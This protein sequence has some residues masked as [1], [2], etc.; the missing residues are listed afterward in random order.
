[1]YAKDHIG[2]GPRARKIGG[3]VLATLVGEVLLILLTTVA[4]EIMFDGINYYE[5]SLSDIFFGGLAT[6]LA[7]VLSG[8]AASVVVGGRTVIPHALISVIVIIETTSLILTGVVSGPAWFDIL[9]GLSLILG[10]WAGHY[11]AHT[12]LLNR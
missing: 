10:V 1:M 12:F 9:G 11:A 3:I 5:S 6:F 4:Q 7:A 8:M 2:L